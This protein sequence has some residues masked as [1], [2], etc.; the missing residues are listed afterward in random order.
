VWGV[1]AA[2]AEGA[3]EQAG[4]DEGELGVADFLLEER[5]GDLFG[6]SLLIGGNEAFAVFLSE[7]DGAAFAGGKIGGLQFAAIEEGK[8]ET[9]H[10]RAKFFHQI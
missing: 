9:F 8:S 1:V 2:F 7:F 5:V 10:P 4:L 6:L 3:G